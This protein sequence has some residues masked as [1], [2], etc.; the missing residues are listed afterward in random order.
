MKRVA[1]ISAWSTACVAA[2]FLLANVQ[3][4][5]ASDCGWSE[6]HVLIPPSVDR[7]DLFGWS[8]DLYEG[9]AV[10]G[11]PYAKGRSSATG[12]A[13]LIDQ[14]TGQ[15][16]RTLSASDGETEDLF[17][18][19]VAI[20]QEFIAV[21]S[22]RDGDQGTD[23]GAVYIFDA[24]SGIRLYKLHS[25][26]AKAL[27]YF[28]WRVDMH[29]DR[30]IVGTA[31]A[32]AAYVF[33]LNTGDE[34]FRVT[35]PD[36]NTT[37]GFGRDVG[38]GGQTIAVGAPYDT[39]GGIDAGAVF[40]FDAQTGDLLRKVTAVDAT[41]Y[42]YFGVSV[43]IHNRMLVAGAH[44]ADH[45]QTA[46]AGAAYVIDAQTGDEWHK[47][48]APNPT[49][50]EQFGIMVSMDDNTVIVGAQKADTPTV[51][52]G[53]AFV[54][55]LATGDLTAVLEPQTGG[56]EGDF[57]GIAVAVNNRQAIVGASYADEAGQESGV[58]YAFAPDCNPFEIS[59]TEP[60]A[61]DTVRFDI[62]GAQ[63][64][65]RTWFAYSLKGLGDTRVRR[66]HITLSLQHPRLVAR[67]RRSDAS[68][69]MTFFAQMPHVPYDLD[70]WFQAFQQDWVSN[71]IATT[72]LAEDQSHRRNEWRRYWRY[73]VSRH[74][75]R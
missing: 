75:S 56:Q 42:D 20:G 16:V 23:S 55:E 43:A 35:P 73:I 8:V 2:A 58:A 4:V 44:L 14:S 6:N 65:H 67:A 41:P 28:G 60:L 30:L 24:L 1:A 45:T 33:D 68:G 29:E 47:L 13:F 49:V 46:D 17:G 53:L 11:A 62:Q 48:I 64:D 51:D 32:A 18:Y 37:D 7:G 31:W 50:D 74:R 27:D 71:T 40:L 3:Y 34:I 12:A 15:T 66:L 69:D 21:S 63:P 72:I 52:A 59:P 39:D 54:Y 36:F 61:R 38:I 22:P 9:M 5:A 25:S 26:D 57:F 19:A 70:I 10:V